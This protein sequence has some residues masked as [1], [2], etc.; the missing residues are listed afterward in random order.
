M[1]APIAMR[2]ELILDPIRFIWRSDGRCLL[3]R[4]TAS[5]LSVLSNADISCEMAGG[6][7]N[8]DPNS[9][10]VDEIGLPKMDWIRCF[11]E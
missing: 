3:T 1:E 10:S 9:H 6:K 7:Q 2:G 8:D 11:T 4:G 5:V